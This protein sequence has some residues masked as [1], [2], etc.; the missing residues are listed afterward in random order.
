MRQVV[1][2]LNQL[3][4]AMPAVEFEVLRPHL[5]FVDLVREA[6]LIEAGV[7]LTHVYL[8]C[9]GIISAR[10][11]LSKGQALDV[12]MVGCDGVVG[13]SAGFGGMASLT[14]AVVLLPGRACILH[15]G[16]VLTA[17]DRSPA[18]RTLLARH[19]Q[20][21]FAQAQQSA[22]CNAA[23]SVEARLSR[24]LLHARDL[25]DSESLPLTQDVLAQMI[26]VRRNA[27][28]IVA[29][30]L[31]KAGTIRYSRGLIEITDVR[32]L[33]DTSCECYRAVR[34]HR[35]RLLRTSPRSAG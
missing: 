12:A 32:G 19:E 26:G 7:P 3:L 10:V 5:E 21:L 34:A 9:S 33:R 2:P 8:P 24:W 27:V 17:A 16:H 6:V 13:A 1:R 29:N 25:C 23:H 15:V 18:F 31:Q 20:A 30:A 11:R 35:D 4:Q 22:A 14:D 28:S